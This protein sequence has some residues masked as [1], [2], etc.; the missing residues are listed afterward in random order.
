MKRRDRL[1]EQIR[2]A[3]YEGDDKTAIRI[4]VENRISREAFEKAVALGRSQKQKK[5]G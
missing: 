2:V 1:L 5:E 3:A 4:Y